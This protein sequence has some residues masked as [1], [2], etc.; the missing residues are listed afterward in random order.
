MPQQH[1]QHQ[2]LKVLQ[3]LPCLQRADPQHSWFGALPWA[4][5]GSMA[6]LGNCHKG[7]H[8]PPALPVGLV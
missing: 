6:D 4:L 2:E 1:H 3:L 8:Q 5:A 7:W